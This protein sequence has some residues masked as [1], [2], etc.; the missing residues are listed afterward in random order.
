MEFNHDGSESKTG[1]IVWTVSA[2]V[3]R[4]WPVYANGWAALAILRCINMQRGMTRELAK[5][6]RTHGD[7]ARAMRDCKDQIISSL[8]RVEIQAVNIGLERRTRQ[9]V[10]ADY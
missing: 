5:R 6:V 1:R 3:A 2:E 10:C 9:T 4:E 8:Q 7:G